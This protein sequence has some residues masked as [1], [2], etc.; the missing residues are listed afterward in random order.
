MPA[1]I[2]Q[3][4]RSRREGEDGSRTRAAL[5]K[6]FQQMKKRGGRIAD[7]D[8]GG[9]RGARPTTSTAAAERVVL[10][11]R[12]SSGTRASSSVQTISFRAGSRAR[13]MPAATMPLSHRMG[14]AILKRSARARRPPA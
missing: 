11:A 14:S 4:R 12:A 6:P 7:R 2:R 10:S 1:W 5:R 9:R 8:H 3:R 13:M